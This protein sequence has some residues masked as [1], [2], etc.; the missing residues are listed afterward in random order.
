[1]S[2]V[3]GI[4]SGVSFLG[5]PGFTYQN[6]IAMLAFVPSYLFIIPFTT[7]V[8]QLVAL[9]VTPPFC[10]CPLLP[11]RPHATSEPVMAVVC[12]TLTI[13]DAAG[14]ARG[15]V[16]GPFVPTSVCAS[17]SLRKETRGRRCQG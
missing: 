14:E 1:M 17:P 11:A 2:L 4:T 16:K 5:M 3:S 6:G 7:F 15:S 9:R 12:G 13:G 10:C 8:L